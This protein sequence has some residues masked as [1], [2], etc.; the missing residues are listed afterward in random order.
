LGKKT[1][2]NVKRDW[3]GGKKKDLGRTNRVVVWAL[4]DS[5]RN[6][7]T[8]EGEI[9]ALVGKEGGGKNVKFKRGGEE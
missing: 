1:F 3:E 7:L 8:S 6:L 4:R 5:G 9:S 2:G